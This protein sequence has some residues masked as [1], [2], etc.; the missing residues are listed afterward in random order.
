MIHDEHVGRSTT[1][2]EHV[3]DAKDDLY[4]VCVAEAQVHAILALADAAQGC[5]LAL[6]AIFNLLNNSGA[7]A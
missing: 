4:E 6:E 7:M 3:S 2:Y 1:Y 5:R